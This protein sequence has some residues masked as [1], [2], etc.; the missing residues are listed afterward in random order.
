M[1]PLTDEEFESIKGFLSKDVN[2]S[3]DYVMLL[4]RTSM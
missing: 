4:Y 1:N 3:D 2:A